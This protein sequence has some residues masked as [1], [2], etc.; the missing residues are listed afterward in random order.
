MSEPQAYRIRIAGRLGP[1]WSAWLG[2]LGLEQGPGASTTLVG[3]VRD[4]AALHGLLARIR[5]LGLELISVERLDV[6]AGRGPG[7][8]HR[9]HG[10]AGVRDHDPA[11]GPTP[12]RRPR[13]ED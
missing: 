1:R 9:G 2:G 11:H 7:R 12:R 5:D 13:M 8:A 3:A 10:A 4:Q 6:P